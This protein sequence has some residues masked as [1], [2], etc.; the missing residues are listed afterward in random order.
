M[1]TNISRP[2]INIYS[3]F[4]YEYKFLSKVAT[5]LKH[6]KYLHKN[7]IDIIL[8]DILISFLR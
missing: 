2:N 7:F 1:N 4:A 6:N 5:V 8:R 3:I